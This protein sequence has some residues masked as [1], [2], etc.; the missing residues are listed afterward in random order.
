MRQCGALSNTNITRLINCLF[1]PNFS[2]G[3]QTDAQI[4]G[5]K[6]NGEIQ[7]KQLEQWEPEG[8]DD[9]DLH[10]LNSGL[11]VCIMFD[12]FSMINLAFDRYF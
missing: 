9:T 7:L 12:L 10:D 5:A 2:D 3:F 6:S 11:C 4:S 1:P 8:S